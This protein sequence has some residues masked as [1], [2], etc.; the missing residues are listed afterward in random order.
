MLADAWASAL[1]VA[2]PEAGLALARAE[3][4]AAR[5]VARSDAGSVETFSPAFSAL[6]VTPTG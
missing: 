2:G 3:R 4:L 1:I 5:F 6:L